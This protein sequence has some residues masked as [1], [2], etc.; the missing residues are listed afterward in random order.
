MPPLN[1]NF[2]DAIV[3]SGVLPIS[4]LG[5]S[6]VGATLESGEPTLINYGEINPA[7]EY[8][9]IGATVWYEWTCGQ[10][11][12]Y[13]L[14]IA[15]DFD[16]VLSVYTGASVETLTRIVQAE[17]A[18]NAPWDE[19]VYFDGIAGTTYRIQVAGYGGDAGSIDLNLDAATRPINDNFANAIALTGETGLTPGTNTGASVEV[20]EPRLGD[21]SYF[22]V[23]RTVWYSL[24]VPAGLDTQVSVTTD[25]LLSVAI[26]EGTALDNLALLAS[27]VDNST[28]AVSKS[29]SARSFYIQIAGRAGFYSTEGDFDLEAVV[30]VPYFPTDAT[31]FVLSGGAGTLSA[32]NAGTIRHT[33]EGGL[34]YPLWFKWTPSGSGTATISGTGL[35][36]IRTRVFQDNGDQTLFEF[37]E[38]IN[39]FNNPQ[40]TFAY[41]E[42]ETYYFQISANTIGT[43]TAALTVSTTPVDPEEAWSI[44]EF[45]SAG[46]PSSLDRVPAY[47]RW[48]YADGGWLLIDTVRGEPDEYN[49]RSHRP[50]IL[51]AQSASGPWTRYDPFESDGGVERQTVGLAKS[52]TH[53]AIVWPD[54]PA[55]N[56][57]TLYY[58]TDNPAS[59]STRT[60]TV[61]YPVVSGLASDGDRWAVITN[62]GK[63]L[64]NSSPDPGEGAFAEYDAL[65]SALVGE[66]SA[67]YRACALTYAE[68]MWVATVYSTWTQGPGAL[69]GYRF[70]TASSPSGPWTQRSSYNLIFTPNGASTRDFQL[71]YN[72]YGYALYSTGPTA[73]F[74]DF[75]IPGTVW[76]TGVRFG[77]AIGPDLV[78][79]SYS[80]A[81][82]TFKFDS[83][84][85]STLFR[86]AYEEPNLAA[87]Y[88]NPE[89]LTQDFGPNMVAYGGGEWIAARFGGWAYSNT[90]PLTGYTVIWSRDDDEAGSWGVSLA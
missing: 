78:A 48:Q 23:D 55:L 30:F 76:L 14:D 67:S 29:T 68:N 70:Y 5:D 3:L 10:T 73:L 35:S 7:D 42:G 26:Y 59:G 71:V 79:V 15:T 28:I 61:A 46:Y 9:N 16:S 32:S 84:A 44:S 27:G 87:F 81:S 36:G 89:T 18:W 65:Q 57:A 25:R 72:G 37:A 75:S 19:W 50:T 49:Y 39:P 20:G 54:F 40:Q 22:G 12:V 63:V 13:R 33:G 1:D 56:S 83:F 47:C 90:H 21:A 88:S 64:A 86:E 58:W 34:L 52:D 60:L 2:A 82:K 45:Q 66:F 11:A 53:W 43:I 77:I 85:G 62:G 8:D 6:N 51:T 74:K 24:P 38:N 17:I 80:P 4:R 31:E 41:E 69:T